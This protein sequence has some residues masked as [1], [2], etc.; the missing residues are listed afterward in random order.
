MPCAGCGAPWAEAHHFSGDLHLSGIALKA[1]DLYAVPLCHDCHDGLHLRTLVDWRLHQ[2]GWLIWT[3]KRALEE[4]MLIRAGDEQ[5]TGGGV[6]GGD[7]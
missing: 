2:R 5:D 6:G 4:G 1:P 3:W 7:T